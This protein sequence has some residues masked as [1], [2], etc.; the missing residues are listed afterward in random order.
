MRLMLQCTAKAQKEM[1]HSSNT[2]HLL[3]PNAPFLRL[4]K[5]ISMHIDES[6]SND[7]TDDQKKV[8]NPAKMMRWQR[9]A[10]LAV[11]EVIEVMIVSFF[12]GKMFFLFTKIWID[13]FRCFKSCSPCETNDHH[14]QRS[15]VCGSNIP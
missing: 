12:K 13:I 15:G 14:G 2:T 7:L 1:K 8:F 6:M 9:S 5:E 10:V 4:V 11:Q 3:I